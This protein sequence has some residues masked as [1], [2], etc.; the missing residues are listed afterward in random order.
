MNISN[1]GLTNND[2]HINRG[3]VRRHRGGGVDVQL[4]AEPGAVKVDR[5]QGCI[6]LS[7]RRCEASKRNGD[8]WRDRNW[9][10]ENG[11]GTEGDCSEFEF[12]VVNLGK[13]TI[14]V[15]GK[16][17]LQY[18]SVPLPHLA[19]MEIG[20]VQLL[21]AVASLNTISKAIRRTRRLTSQIV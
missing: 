13:R 12:K 10:D 21:F 15:N 3:G 16:E 7:Q 17:I 1:T 18:Q 5:C 2:S 20:P 11:K 4:D 19:L 14:H 6:Y 8:D 9:T